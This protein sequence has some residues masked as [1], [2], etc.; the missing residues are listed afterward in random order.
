MLEHVD[1]VVQGV[2]CIVLT[3]MKAMSLLFIAFWRDVVNAIFLKYSKEGRLSAN[4]VGIWNISS[5][6]SLLWWQ[7]TLPDGIWV[8][9][10]AGVKCVKTALDAATWNLNLRDKCFETFQWY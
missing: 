9:T 10:K 8:K 1:V 4:Y 5:N 6:I 3:K 7:K 2:Y